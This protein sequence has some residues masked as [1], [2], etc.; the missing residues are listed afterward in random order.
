MSWN[1]TNPVAEIDWLLIPRP[2][3]PQQL[4]RVRVFSLT[5]ASLTLSQIIN[6]FAE[7]AA[8]TGIGAGVGVGVGV[9]VGFGVGAGAG[10]E[11]DVLPNEIV[12]DPTI[13]L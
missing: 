12:G 6:S 4:R 1:S 2:T 8:G 5:L 13:A 7:G 10:L 9:G 11:V 3:H